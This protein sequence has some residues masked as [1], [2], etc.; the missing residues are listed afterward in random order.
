MI[1]LASINTAGSLHST[2]TPHWSNNVNTNTLITSV[3]PIN[4]FF[5]NVHL[6]PYVQSPLSCVNW[7]SLRLRCFWRMFWR[8]FQSPHRTKAAQTVQ[9]KPFQSGPRLRAQ[10]H[11][12]I[13]REHRVGA[14]LLMYAGFYPAASDSAEK[15]QTIK[16]IIRGHITWST[17][18][19]R[20][21]IL[22]SY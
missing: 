9:I 11:E 22:G 16:K 15:Q 8:F 3:S 17:G 21:S 14:V 2:S 20:F 1:P 5:Y 10:D 4:N 12:C 6:F 19:F 13:Q 7:L 18:R